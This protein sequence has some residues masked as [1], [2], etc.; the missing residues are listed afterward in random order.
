M[1]EW[2]L[3]AGE[4]TPKLPLKLP[5][6]LLPELPLKLRWPCAQGV[7][8]PTSQSFCDAQLRSFDA[9]HGWFFW[10]LRTDG[11]SVVAERG[12]DGAPIGPSFEWDFIQAVDETVH[13]RSVRAA[14]HVRQWL[15]VQPGPSPSPPPRDNLAEIYA[16]IS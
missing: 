16:E 1:G 2:S 5:P 3:D 6:K 12:A 13:P 15:D 11:D 4:V 14:T 8:T 7:T 10:T 9:A